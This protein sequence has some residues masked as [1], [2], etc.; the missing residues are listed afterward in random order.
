MV[1]FI[2]QK[3]KVHSYNL[4]LWTTFPQVVSRQTYNCTRFHGSTYTI[5]WAVCEHSQISN[6]QCIVVFLPKEKENKDIVK[7]QS[8]TTVIMFLLFVF[9]GKLKIVVGNY[10]W[11]IYDQFI[12]C[13]CH[14]PT[15]SEKDV[16]DHQKV[17][18]KLSRFNHW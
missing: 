3:K 14:W 2:I 17:I 7:L 5:P 11:Q 10:Y 6:Q 9:L 1:I 16:T 12:S 4:H 18:L 13:R 15:L 8:K